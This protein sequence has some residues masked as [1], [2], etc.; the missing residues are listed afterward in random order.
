MVTFYFKSDRT[1]HFFIV[2]LDFQAS[3][4]LFGG[5]FC[6]LGL[7]RAGRN[8]QELRQARSCAVKISRAPANVC[9]GLLVVSMEETS[10]P[11]F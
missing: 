2:D 4:Q 3:F 1:S 7:V 5:M 10:G 8:A 11:F 9:L 6:H